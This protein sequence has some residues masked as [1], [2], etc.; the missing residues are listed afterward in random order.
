MKMLL[1]SLLLL[2]AAPSYSQWVYKNIDNKVDPPYKIAY[3]KSTDGSALLKIENVDGNLF[4]YIQGGYHCDDET[5]VDIALIVGKE[6]FRYSFSASKSSDSAS[7]FFM[8][9]LLGEDEETKA[10]LANFKAS[11]EFII[12]TN[13]SH[14]T[15]DYYKFLMSGSTKAVEFMSK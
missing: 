1:I 3:S 5:T 8:D 2:V 14:C 4:L 13:E 9:N 10:F 7:I 6:T 15:D 12:R 11:S